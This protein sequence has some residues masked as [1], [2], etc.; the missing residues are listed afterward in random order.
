MPYTVSY[1]VPRRRSSSVLK[2]SETKFREVA[3]NHTEK[4]KAVG[5]L[6]LNKFHIFYI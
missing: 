5:G 2:A 6:Q 3:Y 1:N 4:L